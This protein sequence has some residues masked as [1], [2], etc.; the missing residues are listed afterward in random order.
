MKPVNLLLI[1]VFYCYS[2]SAFSIDLLQAYDTALQYDKQLQAA[3]S[4]AEGEREVMPQAIGQMLPNISFTGQENQN[5]QSGSSN[6]INYPEKS[7]PSENLV[8]M[9][10]QAVFRPALYF[11]YRQ[12]ETELNRIDA[13]LNRQYQETALKVIR[14]YIDAVYTRERLNLIELQKKRYDE[15]HKAA[16]KN[17]D[18]GFGTRINIDEAQAKIDR[19]IADEIQIRLAINT[20]ANQLEVYL[21]QA[22]DALQRLRLEIFTESFFALEE[23]EVYKDLAMRYNTEIRAL[24][25]SLESGDSEV[26]KAF[27]G[28]LPTV[29]LVAQYQENSSSNIYNVG[30]LANT[31]SIGLQFNVPI[32]SGGLVNSSVRQA[33]AKRQQVREQLEFAQKDVSLRVLK[34]HSSVKEGFATI[35]A[36]EQAVKSSSQVVLSNR[37]G[38]EAGTRTMLNLL[39]AEEQNYKNVVDL[40]FNRYKT[41]SSWVELLALTDGAN[42]DQIA[43]INELFVNGDKI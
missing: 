36:L 37:K 9:L 17:F 7:Y 28:H 40:A 14:A 31:K 3:K 10:K 25:A 12:A 2:A 21:G 34:A 33:S 15:E 30:S 20:S 24:E 26:K 19:L 43:K 38:I 4:K 6:N 11:Q 29:D 22:V 35:R 5:Y 18:L 8:L 23:A 41:V 39:D 13:E 16:V 42:R 27:T 1:L 32:F